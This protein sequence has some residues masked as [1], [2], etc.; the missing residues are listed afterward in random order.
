C[1]T[2]TCISQYPNSAS[3]SCLACMPGHSEFQVLQEAA[4]LLP[5]YSTGVG[6]AVSSRLLPSIIL[7]RGKAAPA[8]IVAY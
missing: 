2:R 4:K 8:T 5:Q 6:K 7:R 3:T 1:K